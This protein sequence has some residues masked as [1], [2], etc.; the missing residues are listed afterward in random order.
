MPQ[1]ISRLEKPLYSRFSG[2]NLCK[3]SGNFLN[4]QIH[5][6]VISTTIKTHNLDGLAL[7][8]SSAV[9]ICSMGLALSNESAV[10]QLSS[11]GADPL[12]LNNASAVVKMSPAGAEIVDEIMI[13]SIEVSTVKGEVES[14]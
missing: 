5:C 7:N 10:V 12:T 11:G 8:N 2:Q 1:S 6:T 13:G 4:N 14:L 3:K 9:V